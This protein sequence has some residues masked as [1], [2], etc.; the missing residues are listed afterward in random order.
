M[1]FF[2]FNYKRE[3]TNMF[4]LL[5]YAFFD[6]YTLARKQISVIGGWWLGHFLFG[7]TFL[8]ASWPAALGL[9]GSKPE[10]GRA[11]QTVSFLSHVG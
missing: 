7:Q 2:K 1:S 3:R 8:Q 9:A 10:L 11:I 6:A 4:R 5:G